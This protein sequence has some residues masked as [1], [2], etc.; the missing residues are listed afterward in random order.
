ML[1]R[2]SFMSSTSTS[3]LVTELAASA[4]LASVAG[5]ASCSPF[6]KTST[7]GG[8]LLGSLGIS[9]IREVIDVVC[10]V[11]KLKRSSTFISIPSRSTCLFLFFWPDWRAIFQPALH[12]LASGVFREMGFSAFAAGT[13]ADLTTIVL[14]LGFEVTCLAWKTCASG[15]PPLADRGFASWAALTGTPFEAAVFPVPTGTPFEAVLFSVDAIWLGASNTSKP[16]S[17]SLESR[18]CDFTTLITRTEAAG[19]GVTGLLCSALCSTVCSAAPSLRSFMKDAIVWMF[20]VLCSGTSP[21]T[22]CPSP[23]S[24]T[25]FFCW[26]T[27]TFF[28]INSEFDML[29]WWSSSLW[30]IS[31]LSR[32]IV[33]NFCSRSW[34]RFITS[35]PLAYRKASL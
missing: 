7:G 25:S 3:L 22:A 35:A 10:P 28:M 31:I 18:A 9:S 17:V 14:S 1:T 24:L 21:N 27:V 30:R 15:F 4:G 34:D 12:S 26:N 23:G 8:G 5:G 29:E 2:A 6:Q 19:S 33:G 32:K 13:V 11:A 16:G 20:A